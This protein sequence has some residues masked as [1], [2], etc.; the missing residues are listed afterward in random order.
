M[1]GII[2]TFD[3]PEP[4]RIP[5]V[6]TIFSLL[7]TVW[8]WAGWRGTGLPKPSREANFSGANGDREKLKTHVP[9]LADHEQ[10]WQPYLIDPYSC[11]MWWRP[12]VLPTF[13]RLEPCASRSACQ[14]TS[15]QAG[16]LVFAYRTTPLNSQRSCLPNPPAALYGLICPSTWCIVIINSFCISFQVQLGAM[17]FFCWFSPGVYFPRVCLALSFDSVGYICCIHLLYTFVILFTNIALPSL[18]VGC[19]FKSGGREVVN[20][21]VCHDVVN[22]FFVLIV[23]PAR[24]PSYKKSSSKAKGQIIETPSWGFRCEMSVSWRPD[25]CHCEKR[26]VRAYP[27]KYWGHTDIPDSFFLFKLL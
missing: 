1:D 10:D 16:R 7:S 21:M 3:R 25:V 13:D 12:Y 15:F 19:V 6:S 18:N 22:V 5:Y 11:Y 27:W 4:G 20:K 14:M 23:R 17:I 8:R 24:D 2:S 9:C 26:G